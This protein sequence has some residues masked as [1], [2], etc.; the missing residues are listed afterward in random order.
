M[1]IANKDTSVLFVSYRN[2]SILIK[3]KHPISALFTLQSHPRKTHEDIFSIF[4]LMVPILK[5]N[6]VILLAKRNSN[7]V[8]YFYMRKKASYIFKFLCNIFKGNMT[9]LCHEMILVHVQ[10]NGYQMILYKFLFATYSTPSSRAK[11][12]CVFLKDEASG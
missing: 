5:T 10:L 4:V 12:K 6:H 2:S 1:D 9:Q 8:L 7:T 3:K 11:L